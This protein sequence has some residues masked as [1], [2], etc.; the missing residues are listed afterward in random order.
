MKTYILF[1]LMAFAANQLQAQL[2]DEKLFYLQKAEK[3]RRMKSTGAV[4]TATGT[5]AAIVGIVMMSNSTYTTTTNS[6]GQQVTTSTDGNA[7]GGALTFLAGAA[8]MGAGIPLWIVGSHAQ[9]KYQRK[10]DGLALRM[11]VNQK[12]AG[13]T[14]A[15]RFQGRRN[16]YR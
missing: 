3:Y 16:T 12:S 11:N 2:N 5:I 9:N 10:L 1:L 6:Y 4:L 13:L 14:V 15:W 8:A 7:A